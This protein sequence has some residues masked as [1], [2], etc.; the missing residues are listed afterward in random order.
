[1][2]TLPVAKTEI[3][4]IRSLVRLFSPSRNYSHYREYLNCNRNVIPHVVVHLR[5]LMIY[6]AEPDFIEDEN[7]SQQIIN[8]TKIQKLNSIAQIFL[9]FHSEFQTHSIGNNWSDL[10]SY[11]NEKVFLH[12]EE[13][14]LFE[15]SETLIGN[16][17][18]KNFLNLSEL[19]TTNH[20]CHV[21]FLH[22]FSYSFSILFYLYFILFDFFP[23]YLT[24]NNN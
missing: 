20:L 3:A 12:R 22:I 16:H 1:M 6:E 24:I 2:R 14:N 13:A 5:D 23:L 19:S 11:L 18:K 17:T 21:C 15:Y 7:F 4:A 9:K 8:I 10:L